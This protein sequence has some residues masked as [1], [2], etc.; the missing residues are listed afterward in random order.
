MLWWRCQSCGHEWQARVIDRRKTTSPA[1][2]PACSRQRVAEKLRSVA[3]QRTL[4]VLH[5][6]LAAGL[7]PTRNEGVDLSGLGAWLQAARVVAL[8]R[9]RA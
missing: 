2:C 7:H 8:R 4:A 9:L 6:A 5:P 1:P 3:P